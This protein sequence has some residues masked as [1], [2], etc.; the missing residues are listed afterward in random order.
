MSWSAGPG[1]P[2][3]APASYSL[4]HIRSDASD[5][6]DDSW[7]VATVTAA[8]GSADMTYWLQDLEASVSYDLQVQAAN[9]AGS[10]AWSATA[11]GTTGEAV[12]IRW[13]TCTPTRPLPGEGVTC[14]LTLLGGVR[15]DDTFAWLAEDGVPQAGNLPTFRT[16]WDSSGSKQLSVEVCSAGSCDGK[17]RTIGVEDPVPSLIWD[18]SPPPAEIGL[19][20]S[21]DLEFEITKLSRTGG[22]GGI[23]VSFPS[24]TGQNLNLDSTS[25]NSAQ[26]VVETVSYT[27]RGDRVVYYDTGGGS[28]LEMQDG[29]AGRP[30]HL[31]VATDNDYWPRSW[32]FTPSGRTL[33]LK[34]TPKLEGEFRVLYRMW[35][36]DTDRVH[37]GRRPMQDGENVTAFDQQGWAAFEYT[38]NVLSL[39][40]IVSVGCN[41][42]PAAV[43]ETVTCLPRLSG[44]A[45]SSYAWNAGNALAGGTPFEG[46][47]YR[48]DTAWSYAGQQ[49]VTLEVCNVAGCDTA[50]Q[51]VTVGSAPTTGPGREALEEGLIDSEDGGR[52]L[53]SGLASAESASGYSPTDSIVHVKVLPTSPMPTLQVTI[54]D[55]D[56]FAAASAHASPGALAVALPEDAWV[57]YG[58]LTTELY[59]SGAWTPY[60]EQVERTL[61]S[62]EGILSAA[63]RTASTFAGISPAA[64]DSALTAADR[65]G[66][67]LGETG[68]LPLDSIF[69]E[70]YANCV[71]QLSVPWL[72]WAGLTKGVRMNIP[73]SMPADAHVSLAAAFTAAEPGSA[74]GEAALAQLHDLL[75]TGG[76]VPACQPPALA[77]P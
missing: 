39:P 31:A 35:L 14:W 42:S 15:G 73:L 53:Y 41:P 37:C 32:F 51:T 17:D 46:H 36:C 77:T 16:S 1:S 18:Y 34:V 59:F 68:A 60:T 2:A 21:I 63:L 50:R 71:S 74:N 65:L 24:L 5:K 61:L 10:S 55:E 62:L 72:S 47:D 23:T 27:G 8:P 54:A 33:R 49:T 30:R 43:G 56:G 6:S 70:R 12:Q 57:D 75:A 22:P 52:V 44:G 7:S 26:G 4:R 3:S 9:D 19:G 20:E 29:T 69:S 76:D 64:S 25:Y 28:T 13:I 48:F 11:T 45:P 66:W 40:V 38:V 67:A 58:R